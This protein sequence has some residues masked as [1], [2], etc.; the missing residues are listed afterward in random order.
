MVGKVGLGA[1]N[2]QSDDNGCAG[3]LAVTAADAHRL[4]VAFYHRR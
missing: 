3:T 1:T 4:D 2:P